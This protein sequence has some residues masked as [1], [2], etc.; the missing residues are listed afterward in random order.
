M[1]T[2]DIYTELYNWKLLRVYIKSSH[3]TQKSKSMCSDGY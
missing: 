3:H 1:I 2:I